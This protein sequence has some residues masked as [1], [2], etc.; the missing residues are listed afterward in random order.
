[1]TRLSPA[2]AKALAEIDRRGGLNFV[3]WGGKPMG[4]MPQGVRFPTVQALARLGM[5]SR[6]ATRRRSAAGTDHKYLVTKQGR[7]YLT[8]GD[9]DATH[10]R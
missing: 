7:A 10:Q 3:V 2:Q 4:G 5:L 6:I 8:A 9:T 1:M